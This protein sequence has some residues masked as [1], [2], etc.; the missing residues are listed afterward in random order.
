MQRRWSKSKDSGDKCLSALVL[1]LPF[2]SVILLLD[3]QCSISYM[4]VQLPT[5]RSLIG[6]SLN[7]SSVRSSAQLQHAGWQDHSMWPGELTRQIKPGL[8]RLRKDT[9]LL[10][11][12]YLQSHSK[13]GLISYSRGPCPSLCTPTPYRL[14]SSWYSHSSRISSSTCGCTMNSTTIILNLSSLVSHSDWEFFVLIPFT[15]Q[16]Q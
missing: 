7:I 9:A 15:S 13:K 2:R 16:R 10:F 5:P 4:V 1:E 3:S 11:M 8:R 6:I 12:L 14:G